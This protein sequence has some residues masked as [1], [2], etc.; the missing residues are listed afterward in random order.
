MD[1][2][3]LWGR[4]RCFVFVRRSRKESIYKC[5]GV[6]KGW[7]LLRIP[8]LSYD[9]GYSRHRASSLSSLKP[10]H[11][12]KLRATW[13]ARRGNR[14]RCLPSDGWARQMLWWRS[15]LKGRDGGSEVKW[16]SRISGRLILG[17]MRRNRDSSRFA[18][19]VLVPDRK[20][21]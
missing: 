4:F 3:S 17:G 21:N 12:M 20:P 2:G 10:R 13:V 16:P 6:Q 19:L 9:L 8:M 5:C 1:I 14:N 15:L 7:Q 11:V 18:A